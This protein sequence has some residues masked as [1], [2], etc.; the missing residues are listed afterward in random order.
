MRYPGSVPYYDSLASPYYVCTSWYILSVLMA[1][2]A[3][4]FPD[5]EHYLFDRFDCLKFTNDMVLE[6]CATASSTSN[7][8]VDVGETG[9]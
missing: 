8:L 3:I 4:Y 5:S 9:T 2:D 1:G 7:D 6:S